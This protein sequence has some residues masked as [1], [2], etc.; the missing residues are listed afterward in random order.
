MGTCH[1]PGAT[2]EPHTCIMGPS[3]LWRFLHRG[4]QYTVDPHTCIMG[5]SPLW[6]PTPTPWDPVHCGALHLHNGT[7]ST[8]K[9]KCTSYVMI[10]LFIL[11][12]F[13]II[14]ILIIVVNIILLFVDDLIVTP[15]NRPAGRMAGRTASESGRSGRATQTNDNKQNR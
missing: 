10:I 2:V 6:S 14:T 12:L 4:I 9:Y 1:W 3:P 7:Q 13:A 5:P 8:V 11:I 15:P